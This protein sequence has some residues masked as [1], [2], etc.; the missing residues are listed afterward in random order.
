[1]FS[2]ADGEPERRKIRSAHSSLPRARSGV[3]ATGA[4]ALKK[5]RARRH[6][7]RRERR[8]EEYPLRE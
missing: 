8:N 1:M 6:R 4:G 2:L 3:A 5:E 7:E